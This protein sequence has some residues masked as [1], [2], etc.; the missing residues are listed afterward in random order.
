MKQ[1]LLFAGIFAALLFTGCTQVRQS[2]SDVP[3][4]SVYNVSTSQ[5]F[6]ATLATLQSEG[7]AVAHADK[8]RGTIQTESVKIDEQTALA[9]FDKPYEACNCKAFSVRLTITPLSNEKSQLSI[10][11]LSND[12]SNGI[13]E[14]T[15]VSN[16]A[17]KLG[18]NELP[19][20]SKLDVAQMPVVKV[21][22][23]D[24]STV[25][26]YLLD[27]TQRAYLRLKLK[28]GGIMHIERSDV[29]RYTLASES[30]SGRN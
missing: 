27:D 26:G 14:Q 20:F 19:S 25:E 3:L 18:G 15:V 22:L 30:V 29:E 11:V 8:E 9:L 12:N 16:I 13:L 23:K 6:E 2:T 17:T 10:A 1:S 5:L 24:N 7:F 28:S 4:A 21:S